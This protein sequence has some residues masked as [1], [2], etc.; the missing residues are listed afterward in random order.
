[1]KKLNI[2]F[3]AALACASAVAFADSTAENNTQATSQS[4][5]R[6]D[7]AGN[8]QN[9]NFNSPGTTTSTIL[10]GGTV[11]QDVNYSGSYKVKNVPSVGGPN[12]T[13]SND[14]CMG[15]SSGSANG[16]GWGLSF[17]TTWSDDNCKMLKNSRE[18][19]NMGMRAASLALLCG[20][21]KNKEAIEMTGTKCPQSMTA[22]ERRAA[23]MTAAP[24]Q[25]APLA[26][27]PVAP[28][29]QAPV[30]Q[31]PKA[32]SV[33]VSATSGAVV[34]RKADGSTFVDMRTARN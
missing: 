17:G 13:T 21:A 33:T 16:A 1:M 22:E 19:W 24:V 18:L 25:A 5:G 12:L 27:A 29:T 30:T 3:A 26:Q 8:Q 31:A 11:G 4:I 15:S 2:I 34:T 32:E 6:A 14:T 9:I 7:N 10:N 20:D 23:F 28:V